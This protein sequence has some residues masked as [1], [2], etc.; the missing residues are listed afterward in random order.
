MSPADGGKF[1]NWTADELA[2]VI[3]HTLLKPEATV[4]DIGR[5]CEE[6]LQHRFFCV[7]INPV[8]VSDAVRLIGPAPV[9]VCT[10]AGFPLGAAR[11]ETKAEEAR[12][13]I[14]DGAAEV[15]MVLFIGGLKARRDDAVRRDVEAVASVCREGK[16]LCK[17]I[18][19]ACL[20]TATEKERACDICAD[21][22][23]DF[24][25]TSTGL[26]TGGATVEDVRLMSRRVAARGLG[27]KAAGGIRTRA[28]AL[29]MLDAGATRIGSSNSVVIH[30]ET[31]AALERER[32]E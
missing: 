23:A 25:K 20:L 7:C 28:A 11:S 14:G 3:D 19:E 22:G 15:D 30:R 13:A 26:S 21:A 5:L 10:V 18:I 16:A 4:A 31:V 8:F 29:A 6:A 9:H 1:A 12:R 32:D 24:V 2:A 27:V 17:V